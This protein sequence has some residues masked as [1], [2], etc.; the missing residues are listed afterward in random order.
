VAVVVVG[1]SV[2][3]AVLVVAE[4]DVED[5][6]DALPV[7]SA[8]L[9]SAVLDSA[10]LDSIV[11]EGGAW[12]LDGGGEACVELFPIVV[13][14]TLGHTAGTPAPSMKTP[15]MDVSGTSTFAHCLVTVS[16]I[17]MRPWTHCALH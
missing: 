5:A 16:A 1:C 6:L 4:A 14:A 7:A 12:V 9:D 17:L 2:E 10:V 15:M 3:T 11:L 13:M 8:E